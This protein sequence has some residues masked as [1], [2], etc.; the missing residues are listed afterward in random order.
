[1]NRGLFAMA[2]VLENPLA[3]V[4]ALVSIDAPIF[5]VREGM[6]CMHDDDGVV[7]ELVLAP[8]KP[9]AE[10]G[11][12]DERVRILVTSG[13]RVFVV[14][15]NADSRQ[16]KHRNPT[17]MGDLCLWYPG[18]DPA[19]VWQWNDGLLDLITIAH[20]HLQYEEFWRRHGQWP[21]EDAPHGSAHHQL[22]STVMREAARRWRR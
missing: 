12:P 13:Q 7:L 21:V 4:D 9:C 20:R 1:M 10:A 6:V 8:W 16:W 17:V 18:D 2:S 3:V 19:L 11:F 14:A 22:R 5:G 15:Q